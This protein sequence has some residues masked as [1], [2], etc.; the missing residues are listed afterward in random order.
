[1][2]M[3]TAATQATEGCSWDDVYFLGGE[4]VWAQRSERKDKQKKQTHTMAEQFD[5]AIYF[6]QTFQIVCKNFVTKF[7]W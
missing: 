2:V 4:C 7:K 3:V 1:M 5:I 6:F